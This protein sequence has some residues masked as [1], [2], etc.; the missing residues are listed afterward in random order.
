LTA[1]EE[2][3]QYLDE[4]LKHQTPLLLRSFQRSLDQIGLTTL[5][6]V[7]EKQ[8][9]ETKTKVINGFEALKSQWRLKPDGVVS[10]PILQTARDT[11]REALDVEI[12]AKLVKYDEVVSAYN[13]ALLSEIVVPLIDKSTGNKYATDIDLNNKVKAAEQNFYQQCHGDP[14]TDAKLVTMTRAW[15]LLSMAEKASL[16]R[17]GAE[18]GYIQEVD[19]PSPC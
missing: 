8:C 2:F 5:K 14:G 1:R 9:D 10:K 12:K 13:K 16:T 15:M 3:R 4:Q 7:V 17:S 6:P 11:L 18:V 19:V